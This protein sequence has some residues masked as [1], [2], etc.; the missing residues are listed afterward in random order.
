MS[1]VAVAATIT[2][3]PGCE[4][5]VEELLRGL[6]APSRKDRGCIRYVLHR[7]LDDPRIFVFLEA[8]ESRALLQAHLETPHIVEWRAEAPDL[9]EG[10]DVKVLEELA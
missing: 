1:Q 10:M 7:S 2:A 8:W 5:R 3:K 4:P 6:V 9:V